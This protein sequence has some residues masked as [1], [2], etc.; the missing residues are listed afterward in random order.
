LD[1]ESFSDANAPLLPSQFE[2]KLE[3]N[4][5]DAIEAMQQLGDD[6]AWTAAAVG[7]PALLNPAEMNSAIN[8]D[9]SK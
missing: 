6:D 5:D 3:F 8:A 7:A 2:N 9:N 4:V 1:L